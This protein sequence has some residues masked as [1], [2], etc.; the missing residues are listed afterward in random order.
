MTK[1]TFS[2]LTIILSFA[3]LIAYGAE[4]GVV[5]DQNTPVD[6]LRAEA[7]R[8]N[9]VAQCVL[10]ERYYNRQDKVEAVIWFR[11]AAEQGYAPAEYNLGLCYANGDVVAQDKAEAVKWFR[12]AAEQG[13]APAQ[14]NLGLCYYNGD[15]VA[16]DKAEAVNWFRKA[17]EQ[18]NAKA[19]CNLGLCYELGH[20]VTQNSDIALDWYWKSAAGNYEL[21]KKKIASFQYKKEVVTNWHSPFLLAITPVLLLI[22]IFYTI[23]TVQN[24]LLSIFKCVLLGGLIIVPVNFCEHQ[25]TEFFPLLQLPDYS[26]FY[27]AFVVAGFTEETFKFFV[28]LL[29]VWRSKTFEQYYDGI[30]YAVM[31]S[32]GFAMVENV[33]YV[34]FHADNWLEVYRIANV[35]SYLSVPSHCIDGI[36]MGYFFALAKFSPSVFK[37]LCFLILSLFVAVIAHGSYDYLVMK[38]PDAQIGDTGIIPFMLIVWGIALQLIRHHAKSDRNA[39]PLKPHSIR[40]IDGKTYDMYRIASVSRLLM[41]AIITFFILLSVTFWN[42]FLMEDILQ[43]NDGKSLTELSFGTLHFV[44]LCW[45]ALLCWTLHRS[46]NAGVL[47][48]CFVILRPLL[49]V[50]YPIMLL[51]Q[52]N[53]LLKA[54]G[55]RTDFLGADMRQFFEEPSQA[56]KDTLTNMLQLPTTPR[57]IEEHNSIV[58][59][60]TFQRIAF[61][62]RELVQGMFLMICSV[63]FIVVVGLVA[64]LMPTNQDGMSE[65]QIIIGCGGCYIGLMIYI[66]LIFLLIPRIYSLAKPP[67]FACLIIVFWLLASP[68]FIFNLFIL[69]WL[70]RGATQTLTAA[71]Y[72][73]G[74][75]GADMRQFQQT[76]MYQPEQTELPQP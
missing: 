13:H 73:V 7:E 40:V 36:L 58:T 19:Q 11:K 62:Q 20:G 72:K 37:K 1:R 75:L 12:K 67:L 14:G 6:V 31:V 70:I 16:Q 56:I 63:I 3:L 4:N 15:G 47:F 74:F 52:S 5:I 17:A 34:L 51:T 66:G 2:L 25:L 24:S 48:G 50:A 22:C 59:R 35:R 27:N 45:I 23:D 43:G 46:M 10:G 53:Q 54:S 44:N 57:E 69:Q 60:F 38:N 61:C 28:L 18:G 55:Y 76:E 41:F 65:S 30:L 68:I 42:I 39:L 8:N 33:M 26:T 49:W 29:F 21:A 9:P 32:L 71:G 64:Y